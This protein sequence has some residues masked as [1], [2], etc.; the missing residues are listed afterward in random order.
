MWEGVLDLSAHSHAR[1]KR[2][3]PT[4][5]PQPPFQRFIFFGFRFIF[6]I[7]LSLTRYLPAAQK[8]SKEI[9][10]C[11]TQPPTFLMTQVIPNPQQNSPTPCLP[12]Q[13]FPV[14]LI[15]VQGQGGHIDESEKQQG[16]NHKG[17]NNGREKP[18]HLSKAKLMIH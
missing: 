13:P 11:S 3:H 12:Y 4:R 10:P 9:S 7:Q 5:L 18:F 2:A 14:G 17:D 6:P 16:E 15:Y 8:R 1:A